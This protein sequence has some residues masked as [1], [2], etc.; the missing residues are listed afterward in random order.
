[1]KLLALMVG[2]QMCCLQ[3]ARSE[4]KVS[5]EHYESERIISTAF[6]KEWDGFIR[7]W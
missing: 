6:Y 3:K 4:S 2:L 1:M 7:F 5:E